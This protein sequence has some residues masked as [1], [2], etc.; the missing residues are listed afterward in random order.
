MTVTAGEKYDAEVGPEDFARADEPPDPDVSAG[1]TEAP[2]GWT[3]D[4]A[5]GELR[6]KKRPGR[7]SLP[8]DAGKIA[9]GLPVSRAAD[10]APGDGGKRGKPPIADADVAMPKGGVIAAGVNKLYRRAGKILR[11]FDADIGE[12]FIA[13]T[14]REEGDDVDELTVGEAWENLCKTNPRVRR[15]VMKAI[16]GGA[17]GDL[18]MAHAPIGIAFAM[19]PLVQRLIPFERLIASVAEPDEDTPDGEGGLP[20]GMTEADVGDMQ[21]LAEE[22]ARRMAARMGVQVSDEELAEASA[23][24]AGRVPP[25]FRR[26]Q[27]SRQSRAKRAHR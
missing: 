17:M 10:R 25:A 27:P 8:P 26:Q 7:P 6:P 21:R 13:C 11:V 23:K 24:A 14:R 15:F 5:T 12:A 3:R 4:K 1:E 22:Q 20:G 9:E 19:K 2:Y 16:A 18:I